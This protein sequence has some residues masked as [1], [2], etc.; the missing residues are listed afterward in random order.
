MIPMGLNFNV[1]PAERLGIRNLNEVLRVQ[2]GAA[3]LLLLI[4]IALMYFLAF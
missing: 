1:L 3:A 2:R 4:N